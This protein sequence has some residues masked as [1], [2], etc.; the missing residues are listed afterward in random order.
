LSGLRGQLTGRLWQGDLQQGIM[1]CV[2]VL[3]LKPGPGFSLDVYIQKDRTK[4]EV[5][6]YGRVGGTG[7]GCLEADRSEHVRAPA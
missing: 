2:C 6:S 1:M 5:E 7:G 3:S 4:R